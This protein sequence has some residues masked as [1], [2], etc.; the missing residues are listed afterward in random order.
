MTVAYDAT[1][2]TTAAGTG[3]LTW[4]HTPAGTPKGILV[5]IAQDASGGADQVTGVTYGGSAMTEVTGSPVLHS[6][7]E[8]GAAY[9]YFLGSSVPTG[10]H[11]VVV[12]V[13]GAA[14]KRGAAISLTAIGNTQ[15]Q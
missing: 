14:S 12:S 15:I 11:Q 2:A 5:F 9:A 6:S 10:V 13:S 1:S 4:S 3:A 7:G 8:P